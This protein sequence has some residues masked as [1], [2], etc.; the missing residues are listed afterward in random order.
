L[1]QHG[2][3]ATLRKEIVRR[4]AYHKMTDP[5]AVK[6]PEQPANPI[7]EL[8]TP[9]VGLCCKTRSFLTVNLNVM[10]IHSKKPNQQ[11]WKGKVSELFRSVKVQT[12]FSSGGLQKYF[13]VRSGVAENGQDSDPN[14][15]VEQQLSTWRGVRKQLEEDMDVMAD[16]AKTDKTG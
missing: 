2:T 11:A 13:I 6:L 7:E 1:E 16:A 3:P 14:H 9:L 15:V 12:F 8:G 5:R 10:R 4:F